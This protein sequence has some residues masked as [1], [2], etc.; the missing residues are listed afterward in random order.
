MGLVRLDIRV[1][2]EEREQ[3]KN[4]CTANAR[5]QT[6]VVREFIRTLGVTKK[7]SL[8]QLLNES[9]ADNQRKEE[10][11]ETVEIQSKKLAEAMVKNLQRPEKEDPEFWGA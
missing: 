9:A 8:E 3:L 4:Y 2:E 5:S 1:T 10:V 6:E 11:K 7:Y